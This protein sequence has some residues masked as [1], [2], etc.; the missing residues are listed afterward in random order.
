MASLFYSSLILPQLEIP[1]EKILELSDKYK[2][3]IVIYIIHCKVSKKAYAGQAVSHILNHKKYRRYGANGRW[4]CHISEACTNTKDNQCHYLNNA[5]RKYGKDAF[6]VITVGS[7]SKDDADHYETE[8][9]KHY[10]CLYP[11]GYNLKTGGKHFIPTEES[12]T[13]VSNGLIKY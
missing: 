10:N 7:C 9:I 5:I 3:V 11:T 1:V 2:V 12:K 8:T 6:E 13:R 4:N